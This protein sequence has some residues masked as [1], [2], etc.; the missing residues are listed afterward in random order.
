M[1]IYQWVSLILVTLFSSCAVVPIKYD[2]PPT[3]LLSHEGVMSLDYST[4]KDV[5]NQFGSP[6]RKESFD[7][8]ENWYYR[9]GEITN[10]NTIGLM[11][12]TGRIQQD[13]N[14]PYILPINRS[15]V[16]SNSQ[17]NKQFSSSLSQEL[18]LKFWFQNDTVSK[19][20]TFGV[21][22]KRPIPNPDY[23]AAK[24][25]ENA[26]ARTIA[27]KKYQPKQAA[28]IFGGFLGLVLIIGLIGS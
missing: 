12:G 6:T 18:Y 24:A 1:K 16:T 10:S 27:Q 23:D 26:T 14:N 2:V 4:K 17:V 7:N 21:D 19:W 15:V 22:Y 13:P 3:V 25:I 8:V 9:L 5:F 20:E 28:I 11:S